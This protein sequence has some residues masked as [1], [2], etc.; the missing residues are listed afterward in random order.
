MDH[1]LRSNLSF[2]QIS[3]DYYP[4]ACSQLHC[5]LVLFQTFG[6]FALIVRI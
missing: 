5:V 3:V 4:R 1:P 6:E 2:V